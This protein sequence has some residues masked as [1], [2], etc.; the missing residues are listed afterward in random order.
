MAFF[1]DGKSHEQEY[2]EPVYKKE[3]V[4]SSNFE[5]KNNEGLFVYKNGYVVKGDTTKIKFIYKDT[6]GKTLEQDTVHVIKDGESAVAAQLTS[7]YFSVK[8]DSSR[9]VAADIKFNITFFAYKGNSKIPCSA[10]INTVPN[11]VT[12]KSYTDATAEENGVF[13]FDVKEGAY[14]DDGKTDLTTVTP[15]YFDSIALNVELTTEYGTFECPFYLNKAVAGEAS[16]SDI[17]FYYIEP[18]NTAISVN[19]DGTLSKNSITWNFMKVIGNEEPV[20]TDMW[21]TME[22]YED[23]AWSAPVRAKSSGGAAETTVSATATAYRCSIYVSADSTSAVDTS[24]VLV[25]STSSGIQLNLSNSVAVLAVD[26]EGVASSYEGTGTTLFVYDGINQLKCVT[27]FSSDKAGTYTVALTPLNCQIQDSSLEEGTFSISGIKDLD[28]DSASVTFVVTGYSVTGK[29]FRK[30]ISF[31][32]GVGKQGKRG[33]QYLGTS[34]KTGVDPDAVNTYV[35]GDFYL[36]TADGYV[37]LKESSG[38]KKLDDYETY[39]SYYN[40][41]MNDAIS[42][43]ENASDTLIT[44]QTAWFRNLVSNSAFI[45][46]LFTHILKI[47]QGGLIASSN[48]DGTVNNGTSLADASGNDVNLDQNG[49]LGFALDTNGNADFVGLHATGATIEG[50]VSSQVF[51]F[52]KIFK[53]SDTGYTDSKGDFHEFSNGDMWL[54]STD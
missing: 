11:G 13:T 24:T 28:G 54:V 26:S 4:D 6:A 30:S 44:A 29:Y 25:L 15:E 3:S 8:C 21:Y 31:I 1:T 22:T 48:Y 23:G 42:V 18:D 2:F 37:Y 10:V 51:N 16:G 27:E 45:A 14:L 33:A 53:A 46:N 12:Q 47:Q 39:S 7:S 50:T 5:Q 43:T 36:S 20:N 49:K 41:V 9:K 38:W 35:T 34:D 40:Q 19:D 17:V 52:S 32:I